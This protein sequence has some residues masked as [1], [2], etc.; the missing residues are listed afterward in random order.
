[1]RQKPALKVWIWPPPPVALR[2][3][4]IIVGAS[5]YCLV[6]YLLA[7]DLLTRMPGWSAEFGLVNGIVLGV[8]VGIRTRSAFDRWFEG[9]KL[10][11]E[12]QIHARNLALKVAHMVRANPA[13]R[14]EFAALANAFPVA[15]VARLRGESR[16]E[17]QAQLHSLP[18][19]VL[20]LPAHIAGQLL[21]L[22]SRWHAAGKLDLPGLWAME[23]NIRALMDV[24]GNCE[25][26]AMTPIPASFHTLLRHGLLLSLLLAPWHLIHTLGFWAI[27]VQ[28]IVIYFMFGVEL[29]AEEVENPFGKDADDLP[30]KDCC[31]SIHRDIAD[32]L[33]AAEPAPRTETPDPTDVKGAIPTVTSEE[34]RES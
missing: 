17:G 19:G 23:T 26:I 29:T 10:W 16:I 28:G 21:A 4:R 3:W 9:Q 13:D 14:R 24:A 8:L 2:L 25:R 18:P 20:H 27:P 33:G 11:G 22:S 1:M 12:L 15:L 31:L 6:V 30:L 32:I 34:P 5:V 7:A